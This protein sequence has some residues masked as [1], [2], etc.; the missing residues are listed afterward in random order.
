MKLGFSDGFI[1][2][3]SGKLTT[4]S[5][6]SAAKIDTL[7]VDSA[8]KGNISIIRCRCFTTNTFAQLAIPS[9][10]TISVFDV[11]AFD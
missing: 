9:M 3:F 5:A 8:R 11:L 4:V 7:F 1:P 6:L 10:N 2:I